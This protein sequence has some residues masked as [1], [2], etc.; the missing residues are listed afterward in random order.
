MHEMKSAATY[1]MV[2]LISCLLA[3]CG[4]GQTDA[5]SVA[6]EAEILEWRQARTGT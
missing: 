6:Y 1:L 2:P 4:K 5:G 3:A